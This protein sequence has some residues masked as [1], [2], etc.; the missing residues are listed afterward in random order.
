MAKIAY[1]DLFSDISMKDE[2]K[3]STRK[4]SCMTSLMNRQ[5]K[6]WQANMRLL[7]VQERDRPTR[8]RWGTGNPFDRIHSLFLDE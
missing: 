5:T 7:S 3:N 4:Y 6:F 1:P 8:L 2:V